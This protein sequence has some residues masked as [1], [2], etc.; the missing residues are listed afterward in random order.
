VLKH[1]YPRQAYELT[2][3]YNVRKVTLVR[4]SSETSDYYGAYS[5]AGKYYRSENIFATKGA[6]IKAGRARIKR[7]QARLDK[8]GEALK[9]YSATLNKA[10]ASKSDKATSGDSHA[11]E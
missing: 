6:A 5:K 8:A 9:K 1:T 2:T 11:T 10:E 7:I 4:P 3:N